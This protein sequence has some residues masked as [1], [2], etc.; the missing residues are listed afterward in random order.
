MD[1]PQ[2]ET[3]VLLAGLSEGGL[4]EEATERE[5]CSQSMGGKESRQAQNNLVGRQYRAPAKGTIDCP[6]ASGGSRSPGHISGAEP[7]PGPR[8]LHP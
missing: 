5:S 3:D 6:S 7:S 8:Q 4:Q 2:Y 1:Q